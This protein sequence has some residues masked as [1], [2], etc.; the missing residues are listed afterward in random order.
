LGGACVR[1]IVDPRRDHPCLRPHAAR[2]LNERRQVFEG[3]AIARIEARIGRW[4]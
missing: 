4:H 2:H 1:P 3:N